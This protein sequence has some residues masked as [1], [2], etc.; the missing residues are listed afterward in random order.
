MKVFCNN[1]FTTKMTIFF[2]FKCEINHTGFES[3]KILIKHLQNKNNGHKLSK[4]SVYKCRQ[5]NCF[6]KFGSSTAFKRHLDTFHQDL[7]SP[8][9]VNE[10][11]PEDIPGNLVVM[12]EE[13]ND[14][15]NQEIIN[16]EI[17]E[18]I[19]IE[20]QSYNDEP[21]L[22]NCDPNSKN[23]NDSLNIYEIGSKFASYLHSLPTYNRQMVFEILNDIENKILC[24][25]TKI[26]CTKLENHL[27]E[28]CENIL[29]ILNFITECSSL[30]K[31]VSSEHKF[32]NYLKNNVLYSDPQKI[33]ID[34]QILPV[35]RQPD[36]VFEEVETANIYYPIEDVLTKYI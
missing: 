19:N 30:F 34:R 13:H 31:F 20:I 10:I 4:N 32:L 33:L 1:Y 14:D 27:G 5:R 23:I 28:S 29:V 9:N 17:R 8:E 11:I 2:C 12:N 26:I 36:P 24:P 3:S 7:S 16:T 15:A 6:R 35:L 21:R 22:K 25:I 18:Q